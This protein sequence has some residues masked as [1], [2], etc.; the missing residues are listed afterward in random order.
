MYRIENEVFSICKVQIRVLQPVNCVVPFQDATMGPFFQFGLAIITLEDENGN[1]GEA[2]VYSSYNNIIETCLFPILLHS[3][4]IAY[5]EL[6]NH[7]YWSIRNEGFR[8]PASALLGQVDLALHDLAARRS[9]LPL[10]QYLGATRNEV[11]FYGSGGG[12]NYSLEELETEIELFLDAGSECY[13]MKV[14]KDFGT[15]MKEDVSRVKFVRSVLGKEVKLAMDANQIWTCEQALQFIDFCG[16]LDIAWLEE[17]VHSA[18]LDQIEK[19]CMSTS[20]KISYGESER[21]ARVFPSILN[22]GVQHLQP[23]PTQI[24]GVQEWMGVKD[25]A[26]NAKADFSS[27]GYSLFTASLVATAGEDCYT[28]YLYSLMHGLE[29]YFSIKPEWKCGCF[30]LPEVPG[31]ATQIDWDYCYREKKILRTYCWERNNVR[32]YRPMVSI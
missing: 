20:L 7:L 19:L 10:H 28:E 5:S 30:S 1:I 31:F 22:A 14:G 6:Y 11:K 29:D 18:S 16:N 8:G 27:G 21:S 13:K 12:T 24:A 15:K 23:V 9:G 4:D 2:P 25:L 32:E 3:Q 17:P 26:F